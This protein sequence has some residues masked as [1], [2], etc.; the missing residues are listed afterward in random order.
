VK[1]REAQ[2]RDREIK[3][4]LNEAKLK[5]L[6]PVQSK[7]KPSGFSLPRLALGRRG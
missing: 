2:V 4:S 5:S 7:P 1:R 3:A 6:P